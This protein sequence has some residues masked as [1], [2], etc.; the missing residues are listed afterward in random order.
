M[1]SPQEFGA[2]FRAFMDSMHAAAPAEEAFFPARL[3]KHFGAP[4]ETLP[5][6]AHKFPQFETPNVQRALDAL[7]AAERSAGRDVELLGVA[8]EQRQYH[9]PD[10]AS[11]VLRGSRHFTAPSSGPV[12]YATVILANGESVAC[13]Q[14]GLYLIAPAGRPMGVLVCSP[15][16]HDFAGG[17]KVEVLAATREE[18]EEFLAGVRRRVHEV[19]VYRG[20][21]LSVGQ[22]DHRRL[23]LHFHRLPTITRDAIILPEA[24]LQRIERQ[25]IG[26]TAHAQALLAAG[27][28]LKRGVLLH[29]PPGTGKTLTA[30]HLASQ[31]TGRTVVLVTGRGH[32]LL[33]QACWVARSLAPSTVVLEDVDLIAEDRESQQGRCATPLLFE[34]LNQMDGFAEDADVLFLLTTNRP[35]ILEPALAARPGRVDLAIEVPLPDDACRQ[36]LIDL[37]SRGITLELSNPAALVSKTAGA[38]GA[39][40]KELL[41]RATLLAC[42]EGRGPIVADRHVDEALRELVITGGLLNRKLLG[43]QTT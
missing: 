11:L 36:R 7:A 19:S 21:V 42:L 30:M 14:C 37:Y 35:E 32:G 29:G 34:L 3:A 31:M 12:E 39:F 43:F 24:T 27:R 8:S 16:P 25:T 5:I 33:E 23:T 17:M 9:R 1:S 28:H 4:V 22:D 26:F 2:S 40:I 6:V 20:N 15:S 18:A 10:M 38:S 13:V 41:R